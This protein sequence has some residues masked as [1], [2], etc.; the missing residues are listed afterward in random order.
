[1]VFVR[2]LKRGFSF[3][4]C[5]KERKYTCFVKKMATSLCGSNNR[6]ALS[7]TKWKWL[8]WFYDHGWM[9]WLGIIW[10]SLAWFLVSGLYK[11]QKNSS[12]TEP[13]KFKMA[14]SFKK[15]S[16]LGRAIYPSGTRPSLH[17]NHLLVSSGVP[18]MDSVIGETHW[19]SLLR[20]G[21]RFCVKFFAQSWQ[22]W[23]IVIN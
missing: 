3:W 20:T 5:V 19:L 11:Q 12:H 15:K 8:T 2:R 13:Q 14:T 17:N 1:M 6:S 22:S 10:P 16:T 7:L 9:G 23:L 4:S 21:K 18:S